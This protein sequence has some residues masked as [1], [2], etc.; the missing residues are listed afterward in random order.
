MT[1]GRLAAYVAIAI[2][3][4]LVLS[5]VGRGAAYGELA[6]AGVPAIAVV[7]KP[8]CGNHANIVYR[9]EVNGR[10]FDA[11]D[12]ASWSGRNCQSVK[13]GE[14]VRVT[15]L[16]NDPTVNAVGDPNERLWNERISLMLASLIMPAFIIWAFVRRQRGHG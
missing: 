2:V 10:Q 11:R 3:A 15:Y 9:F 1:R 6:R 14:L 5:N 13:P 4:W 7:L 8:D 16:P 12:S